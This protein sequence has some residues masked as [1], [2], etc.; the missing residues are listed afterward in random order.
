MAESDRQHAKRRA[1]CWKQ[2]IRQEIKTGPRETIE[3]HEINYIGDPMTMPQPSSPG[4][5]IPSGLSIPPVP[6]SAQYP[7]VI[8]P[9][10][11][12]NW[13]QHLAP[14]PVIWLPIPINWTYPVQPPTSPIFSPPIPFLN[15]PSPLSPRQADNFSVAPVIPPLPPQIY[16]PA[17]ELLPETQKRSK[18]IMRYS[19]V[20]D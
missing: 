20:W 1:D 10:V 18:A 19:A 13:A 9:P 4:Q 16:P 11:P 17:L 5:P 12:A 2:Q 3:G 8:W 6:N 14:P 15:L 7:L